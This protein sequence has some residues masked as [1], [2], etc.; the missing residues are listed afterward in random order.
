MGS[1][2]AEVVA[3][4]HKVLA[5]LTQASHEFG[6]KLSEVESRSESQN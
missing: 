5:S 1:M 3:E 4:Q 6:P 2:Q